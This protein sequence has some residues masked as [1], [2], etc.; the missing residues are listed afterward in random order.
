MEQSQSRAFLIVFFSNL[1]RNIEKYLNFAKINV[2][3]IKTF[4]NVLK[5]C[6]KA[7]VCQ[8]TH[9]DFETVFEHFFGKFQLEIK[10]FSKSTCI[11]LYFYRN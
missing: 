9:C 7:E 2:R 11:L 8:S 1:Y 4:K 3:L 10:L 6:L 5:N